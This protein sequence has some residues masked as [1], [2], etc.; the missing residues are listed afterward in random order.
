MFPTPTSGYGPDCGGERRSGVSL[1]P[2][3]RDFALHA[4]M[5]DREQTERL[6]I[7]TVQLIFTELGWTFREQPVS[8]FGIDAQ[9]EFKEGDRPTGRLLALQ[10]KSGASYFK[11]RGQ[12]YVYHGSQ[13]HLDYWTN[14]SLPVFI[15][16]HDPDSKLTLWQ[17]IDRDLITE[18]ESGEWSIDIPGNNILDASAVPYLR[19]GTARDPASRRRVRMALDLPLIEQFRGWESDGLVFMK[20]QEWVNKSLTFRSPTVVLGDPDGEIALEMGASLP[21]SD[22]NDYMNILFPWLDYDYADELERDP[23]E[24]QVHVLEVKLNAL[25][26]AFL[27]VE[28]FYREGSVPQDVQGEYEEVDDD[29]SDYDED[30]FDEAGYQRAIRSDD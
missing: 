24:L 6:G 19:H 27:G 25:G 17:K 26:H 11:R 3:L 1:L 5:V 8:D 15:I 10:I 22:I 20:V 7:A 28:D 2:S 14:H 23:P 9:V 30:G 29:C 4:P 18:K 13:R 16:L 21:V 12:G